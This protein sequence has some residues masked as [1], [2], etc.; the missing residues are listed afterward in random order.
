[1]QNIILSKNKG[2]M[3]LPF[4]KNYINC[5]S[6]LWRC[7]LG[8]RKGIWPVKNWVVGCWRGC[9]WWGADL[10]TAQQ[11][12]LPLT[13]SCS[14]KSR[15]VLA[16][17]VLPFWYLLTRVDPDIFQTSSKTVVCECVCVYIS[18][19][20]I[21]HDVWLKNIFLPNFFFGGGATD[22][23]PPTPMLFTMVW[24]LTMTICDYENW[25]ITAKNVWQL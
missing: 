19:A 10:H 9:L 7:W 5:P 23:P 14:S 20:Q 18:T 11:M 3:F 15:L 4:S 13:V 6:V 1:M 2:C 16:F 21:S 8:G 24:K 17:L 25:I 22:P 12:P